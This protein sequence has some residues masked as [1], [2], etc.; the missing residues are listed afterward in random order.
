MTGELLPPGNPQVTPKAFIMW[1]PVF[2]LTIHFR[3]EYILIILHPKKMSYSPMFEKYKTATSS[4]CTIRCSL[5]SYPVILQ[6]VSPQKPSQFYYQFSYITIKCEKWFKFWCVFVCVYKTFWCLSWIFSEEKNVS[7]NRSI[8]CP[9][10]Y[11][12]QLKQAI[13]TRTSTMAEKLVKWSLLNC[14][15]PKQHLFFALFHYWD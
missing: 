1:A 3:S 12:P 8:T 15:F 5:L 10:V 11:I 13:P 14:F 6:W 7:F 4:F 9:L 2:I